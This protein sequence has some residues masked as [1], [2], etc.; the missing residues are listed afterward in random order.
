M[1]Q[2][3][4]PWKTEGSRIIFTTM[5]KQYTSIPLADID[6]EASSRLSK[7]RSARPHGETF[8][9]ANRPRPVL[10]FINQSVKAGQRR[11]RLTPSTKIEDPVSVTESAGREK[12]ARQQAAAASGQE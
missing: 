10:V 1:I 7:S 5:Q 2:T 3:R 8:L 4:G 11:S 12:L 6:L 9:Q